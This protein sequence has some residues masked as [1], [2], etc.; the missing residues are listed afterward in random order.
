LGR[1]GGPQCERHNQRQDHRKRCCAYDP[2]QRHRGTLRRRAL[3]RLGRALAGPIDEDRHRRR[4][5]AIRTHAEIPFAGRNR[6]RRV[7]GPVSR[8]LGFSAGQWLALSGRAAQVEGIL[9]EFVRHRAELGVDLKLRRYAETRTRRRAHGRRWGRR[10]RLRRRTRRPHRGRRWARRLH[11]R[12]RRG[13]RERRGRTRHARE[14]LRHR[15]HR[16]RFERRANAGRADRHAA[17]TAARE[18]PARRTGSIADLSLTPVGV[19]AGRRLP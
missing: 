15:S 14:V 3:A 11:R 19:G 1:R 7:R 9:L 4:A 2:A 5:A 12:G 13:K 8:G 16:I 18:R 17:R 10:G 6:G